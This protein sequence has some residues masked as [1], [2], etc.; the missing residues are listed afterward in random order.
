MEL[1]RRVALGASLAVALSLALGTLAATGMSNASESKSADKAEA[2][3]SVS[4]DA[5]GL[6]ADEF[7]VIDASQWADIYP[8]EYNTY[9][10]NAK[11]APGDYQA[12]LDE[13]GV[14]T[15]SVGTDLV[16]DFTSDKANFL[17]DDQYPEI[18]TLGKGYGYAKYYTEPAG[19]TYSL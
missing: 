10:E 17:D 14:D 6:E 15:T 4:A 8:N 16:D 9:L 1:K 2:A 13:G 12:F 7:G 5:S 3:A 19:H 18:K 11:N